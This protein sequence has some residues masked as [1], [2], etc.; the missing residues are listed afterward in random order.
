MNPHPAD[1]AGAPTG[2]ARA[3][4]GRLLLIPNTLDHDPRGGASGDPRDVLPARVIREAARLRHWAAENARSTRAFLKRIDQIEPLAWPLQQIEIRELPRPP[5]GGGARP[6]AEPSA[7][8]DELLAPLRAGHDLGL[9]SEAG[10]PAVADPGARLVAAA[11]AA[12]LAVEPLSGPSSLMLAL[13]ASGLDGQHF[14]FVGYLPVDPA[15]RA[16]RIRELEATSRR[17]GQTQ[18]AIETPY[19]NPALLGALLAN[20]DAASWLSVSCGLTLPGG[21][22]RSARVAQWRRLATTE[23]ALPDHVPAV[24]VWR[25]N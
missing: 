7:A 22:T 9:I 17:L 12:G 13:A 16:S 4:P 5:K 23:A 11:H 20:L 25:A 6:A 14:A 19:R 3:H 10:L 21:W 24:F 2:H 8:W 15:A 18:I 1:E